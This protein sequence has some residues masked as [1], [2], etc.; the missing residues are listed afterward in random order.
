[1]EEGF[2]RELISKIQTMRKEAGFEVMDKIKVS[3][4]SGKKAA[5][6]FE[7]NKETI[8]AEV[9][10]V[11]ITTEKLGGYEKEWN[12]NGESVVMEVK[13]EELI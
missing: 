5:Q 4:R 2:V 10:A 6:V 8:R 3:Y 7:R 13:K 12:I 9:L 1:M 11:D